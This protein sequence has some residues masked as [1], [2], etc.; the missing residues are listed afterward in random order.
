MKRK[1][2]VMILTDDQGYWTLGCA[3]NPN[4]HTPNIDVLAARGQRFDNFS[5]CHRSALRQEPLS[6]PEIFRR[7]MA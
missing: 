5:A 7:R 3:G 2:V 6:L 4:A 1:N